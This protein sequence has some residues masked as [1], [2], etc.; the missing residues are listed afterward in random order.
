VPL[1]YL[2]G[3]ATLVLNQ[4]RQLADHHFEGDGSPASF[5]SHVKDSCNYSG[6]DLITRFLFPFSIRYHA[7]HHLFPSMPYHNLKSA[8]DHLVRVLPTDS[9]YRDLDQRNWWSVA[10][11]TLLGAK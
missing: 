4:M 2:L 1:L 5:E 11:V 10:Q 3:L 7:L 9:P 8:H 6:F